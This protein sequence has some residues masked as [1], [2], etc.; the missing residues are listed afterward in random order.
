MRGRE[1]GVQFSILGQEIAIDW[2]EGLA[3]PL[4]CSPSKEN[5]PL[6]LR[7][8]RWELR[9][10]APKGQRLN[11]PFMVEAR[12]ASPHLPRESRKL[13][14]IAIWSQGHRALE[15][16]ENL[17]FPRPAWGR[18]RPSKA[19]L[20]PSPTGGV[21]WELLIPILPCRALWAPS[22]LALKVLL[23]QG[24]VDK[25]REAGAGMKE[26]KGGEEIT[27]NCSSGGRGP[28][29]VSR[30]P[31][32]TSVHVQ[33]PSGSVLCWPGFLASTL[34]RHLH[35]PSTSGPSTPNLIHCRSFFLFVC[36][37]PGQGNP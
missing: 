9:R 1:E 12:A 22:Y 18:G 30:P 14:T 21:N 36:W 8:S 23:V 19:Q 31:R 11:F 26:G 35:S 25:M 16:S 15:P 17:F 34:F 32:T 27:G 28:R 13:D 4:P 2:V 3:L 29:R 37:V 10:R 33:G 7:Q 5:R 24:T 20:S 6:W